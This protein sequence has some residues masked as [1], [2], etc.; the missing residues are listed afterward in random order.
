MRPDSDSDACSTIALDPQ[1][2]EDGAT[3]RIDIRVATIV[4]CGMDRK[5]AGRLRDFAHIHAVG[6]RESELRVWTADRPEEIESL[7]LAFLRD[8]VSSPVCV[9][10]LRSEPRSCNGLVER[11]RSLDPDVSL[12]LRLEDDQAPSFESSAG[13]VRTSLPLD[14]AEILHLACSMAVSSHR[15][16]RM[17]DDEAQYRHLLENASDGL[18][19]EAGGLIRFANDQVR[20]LT[21]FDAIELLSRPFLEFIHPDHQVEVLQN[22]ARRKR[23]EPAP[24]A[25]PFRLL[26]HDGTSRWSEMRASRITWQGQPAILAFIADIE[27]RL[28]AEDALRHQTE[29][30]RNIL[31]ATRAGIW[32]WDVIANTVVVDERYREVSGIPAGL[33]IEPGALFS[34]IHAE[35]RARYRALLIEHL[36]GLDNHFDI[37]CRLQGDSREGAWI[38]DRGKV[39]MRDADGR[40]LRVSGTRSDI[41]RRKSVEEELHRTL[42]ELRSTTERAER[43]SAAK[44]EFLANMSH[45][46]RT[47]M[48]AILGMTGLLL[49]SPLTEEQKQY[50]QIVRSSGDALLGLI[51][52]IL[53]LSKIEARKLSIEIMD[54]D[55]RASLED[56]AEMLAVRAQEK[57]LDLALD[58]S[59]EIP[60]LLQGD[61]G[62]IRQI[63]VNLVGNAVKFTES[64]S[65]TIVVSPRGLAGSRISLSIAVRDTGIGMSPE[66]LEL[67]FQPFSQADSSVTRR[68]GGTGL[69]LAISRQLA[70]LMGGRIEV[71]SELGRG[72][73]F[74]LQLE[75]GVQTRVTSTKSIRQELSGKRILVVDSH[76]ASRSAIANHMEAWG[77]RVHQV[78]EESS[79]LFLLESSLA[80][81]DPFDLVLIDSGLSGRSDGRELGRRIRKIARFDPLKLVL[82]TSLGLRGEVAELER[83]GFQGYLTKPFRTSHLR[84]LLKAVLGLETRAPGDRVITRHLVEEIRR[85]SLRILVAEDNRVNQILVRKLLDKLGYDCEVVDNGQQVLDALQRDSFDVILMDCQMPVLDGLEAT[86]RIRAGHAGEENS[87]ISVVALTAHA[88]PDDKILCLE[89]GMDE[90]LTKPI[91]LDQLGEMLRRFVSRAADAESSSDTILLE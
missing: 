68:F 12:V 45:E 38:H 70:E 52:D 6:N 4:V 2:L 14:R 15:R 85:H 90:Y 37:E 31:E 63:L 30:L 24:E 18:V 36:R 67:L 40:A 91:H 82:T 53:D 43:A 83:D 34:L 75:L 32:E 86:R 33:E 11:L 56:V 80:Q 66:Q 17:R 51:N 69:G 46:I 21:G 72:S 59:P 60:S 42:T 19:I 47:P 50:A 76:P 65:V 89:A 41:S 28:R 78:S 73:S 13:I 54:F 55:L 44:S 9:C 48:N 10:D 88:L 58:I 16:R 39:I 64:G 71:A 22:Y 35:D 7:L 27:D 25:Y 49:D 5:F 57:G 87:R 1:D 29:R 8:G 84:G 61:P 79:V 77:C 74:E 26:R 81:S 23:G 3:C 62:R 20:R